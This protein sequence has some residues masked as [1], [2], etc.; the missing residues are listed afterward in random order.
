MTA[1]TAQRSN[2]SRLPPLSGRLVFVYRC[3]W[4]L[5]ALA[6]A[7]ALVMLLRTTTVHPA[8]LTIR[9]VKAA[10]LISVSAILLRRRARDP[11]A[12]LL[13]LAFLS[14][15]VSSSVDFTSGAMLPLLLDRLRFLFFAL[16]L[17]LFPDGRWEPRWTR[18]I[19]TASVATFALGVA[20]SFQLLPTALFLPIAIACVLA[21]IAALVLRFKSAASQAV[22]QQLKWVALGLV[23]GV[24]MILSARMGAELTG[25]A[26]L[27]EALFQ[28]GI[29]TVAFGFLVSLLRYRLFDAESAISRSAA[30]AGVTIAVVATFAGTEA[31]IE[32]VGQQYLG[33]GI[34]N[35]SAAMAAAVAAVLLNPLHER[36]S[37]W[38][39]A[40]FQRDLVLL[41]REVPAALTD[42]AA[43]ATP[44]E[45][46][47]A[48]LPRIAAAIHA[49]SVVLLADDQVIGAWG[50]TP[51][52]LRRLR[53]SFPEDPAFPV[54]VNLSPEGGLAIALLLGPRPD[55]TLYG[56]DDREALTDIQPAIR[57]ALLWAIDRERSRRDRQRQSRAILKRVAAI[58]AKV[59]ATS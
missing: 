4:A 27:W 55:G 51:K 49:T 6:G 13:S 24:G 52:V 2:G 23:S 1:A 40:R 22:R 19:A 35:V 28:L 36:I 38:A 11:V 21:A 48:I 33:M 29:V 34:G 18:G 58:E 53:N 17:L 56:R 7:A 3:A 46:A 31:A 10:V 41:K 12:A 32:L 25:A 57:N 37:N 50:V 30:L 5:L 42:L 47:R 59:A 20:E 54:C 9:L 16:A 45:L 8:V 44:A 15:T 43:R 14:W 26:L 39:E